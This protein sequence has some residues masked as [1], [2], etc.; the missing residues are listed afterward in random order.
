MNKNKIYED[1][2]ENSSVPDLVK[3]DFIIE[4][5]DAR[6]V[7][8]VLKYTDSR[9]YLWAVYSLGKVTRWDGVQ[10]Y[11]PVF[12][13]RH[14]I[15]LVGTYLMGKKK[16]WELNVRWNFGSG[17]PFTQIQGFTQLVDFNQNGI[18]TDYTTAN[19]NNV[20]IVYGN[21]YKGRLSAY[22]RLDIAL[23]RKIELKNKSKIE[24]TASVTNAYSRKNIFYVEPVTN[25]RVYQLPILPSLGFSW[26]F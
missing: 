23:K 13:R 17:L 5:G 16:N 4:T 21:I 10:T 15:N 24:I 6:G 2:P 7:D 12:D 14:N 3:K 1:S 11:S 25:N 20:D 8:V 26:R 19:S 22:H 9:Y 18:G